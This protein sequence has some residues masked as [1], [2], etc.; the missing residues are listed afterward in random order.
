[1]D[2]IAMTNSDGKCGSGCIRVAAVSV[3][4]H[5]GLSH[6][7]AQVDLD[8]AE[9]GELEIEESDDL[10][11]PQ[12]VHQCEV[13]V[14][15]DLFSEGRCSEVRVNDLVQPGPLHVREIQRS[16]DTKCRCRCLARC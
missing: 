15:D 8:R 7:P 1:M 5:E 10:A 14:V 3:V 11:V 16:T 13:T 4:G 12:G 9:H 2:W 6:Q